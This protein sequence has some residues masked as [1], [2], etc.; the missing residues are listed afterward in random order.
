[1]I[2][3]QYFMLFIAFQGIFFSIILLYI[4][5]SNRKAINILF[6]GLLISV[7]FYILPNCIAGF[8]M[9]FPRIYLFSNI[10]IY[11]FTPIFYL[12]LNILFDDSF[13]FHN[14]HTIYIIPVLVYLIFLL[15]Y[16]PMSDAIILKR[17]QSGNFT[18]LYFIDLFTFIFNLFIIYKSWILFKRYRT[19][20]I[21]LQKGAVIVFIG[22]ILINNLLW[23]NKVL[24]HLGNIGFHMNLTHDS[25][26]WVSFSLLIFFPLT[27]L[28]IRSNFFKEYI[29]TKTS[30]G[31]KVDNLELSKV[32]S[33]LIRIMKEQKPYLDS[34]FSLSDLATLSGIK[35]YYLS[36]VMNHFMKTTFFN[37]I[38]SYRLNEFLMLVNL[39]EYKNISLID[40]AYESGFKSKSTFYKMFKENKGQSP[41]DYLKS[42][43]SPY[44]KS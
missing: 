37:L 31:Y 19:Q 27:F 36:R 4:T 8:P 33:I 28:I 25:I 39:K 30:Q 38:N 29:L 1:M 15:K 32:E 24:L 41:K 34:D 7:S 22:F 40:I 26:Y 3:L 16:L 13:K 43:G 10:F 35:Q 9:D 20:L 5:P 44:Y 18:D 23:I 42:I 2:W 12:L 14:K 17:L 11:T 6:S 21:P